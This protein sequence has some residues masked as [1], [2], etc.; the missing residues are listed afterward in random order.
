MAANLTS[1]VIKSDSVSR[2][3]VTQLRLAVEAGQI[4]LCCEELAPNEVRQFR[5]E[6]QE[7]GACAKIVER[8]P[9][10]S[11]LSK[12]QRIAGPG[13]E[14]AEIEKRGLIDKHWTN[15]SLPNFRCHRTTRNLT[16]NCDQLDLLLQFQSLNL[17]LDSNGTSYIDLWTCCRVVLASWHY[18]C[19]LCS[20]RAKRTR[21]VEVTRIFWREHWHPLTPT[22]SL[23]DKHG[24][25][26]RR[27]FLPT[28][29]TNNFFAIA[30]P[31]SLPKSC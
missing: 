4:F 6:Y 3:W 11:A 27:F 1:D 28:D 19:T 8:G 17:G 5:T 24:Q 20:S 13:P 30:R 26:Y 9:G 21:S 15:K 10:A 14:S 16:T 2:E 18:C 22:Y 23:D 31:K 12:E 29:L 7:M 25:R